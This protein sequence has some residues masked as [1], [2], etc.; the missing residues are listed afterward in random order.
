MYRIRV[1]RGSWVSHNVVME[2]APSDTRVKWTL[3]VWEASFHRCGGG[4]MGIEVEASQ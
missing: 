2:Y 1:D 4:A 3:T